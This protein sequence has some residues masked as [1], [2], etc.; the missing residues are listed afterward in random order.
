MTASCVKRVAIATLFTHDR[1]LQRG[2]AGAAVPGV[3]HLD[4][5]VVA[6]LLDAVD[7]PTAVG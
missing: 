3:A 2:R 6:T 7:L 5:V 1:L 4:H